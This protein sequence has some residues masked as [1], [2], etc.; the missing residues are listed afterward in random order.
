MTAQLPPLSLA[1]NPTVALDTWNGAT[2]TQIATAPVDNT[3]NLSSYTATFAISGWNDT[4][5]TPYRLRVN[6]G[7][8]DYEWT[9]SVRR[10]P[11]DKEELVIA[12]HNCQRTND[13]NIAHPD[14]D[15]TPV[16]MWHP[17]SQTYEHMTKHQPDIQLV[18]G[19]Q[20]YE[21]QPTPLDTSSDANRQLDFLYKWYLWMLQARELARDIPTVVIP[22]DHDVF[23]GNLWG[24]GGIAATSEAAGGYLEPAEWV[25]MVERCHALHLPDPDPYHPIQPAP[26]VAQGIGVYF[27]GMTYGRLGFAIL[28]DRKF[29]TGSTAGLPEAEQHLLGERQHTFLRE[30]NKDWAGQD[31]KLTVSQTPFGTLNTH[32]VPG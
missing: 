10:D 20:I 21:P 2:W 27:T 6:V 17:H 11:V 19:D 16:R 14:F 13:L 32:A 29:K 28:E 18:V 12:L 30:W 31:L 9:G 24:A 7:G 15:W 1:G 8:H 25:K 5:D 26:P 4:V 3:D 23:Q 22:D